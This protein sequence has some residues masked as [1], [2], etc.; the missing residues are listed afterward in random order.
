VHH[1]TTDCRTFQWELNRKIQYGTLQLSEEQQRVHKTPFPNH[2]KDNKAVVHRNASD[3]EVDES[4]VANSSLVP[5]AVRTLQKS[6]KFKSLFNQLRFGSKA[7][8]V[9]T[10]ALITIVAKSGATCFTAEAHASHAF[11]EI[12]NVITFTDEDMKVQ[13]LDHRRPLYLSDVV[14]NIQVRLALIDTIRV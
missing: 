11:L 3:M 2:K 5:T 13:Y 12:T 10:E 7:R 8:S 14:K 1:P 4:V 6:P 9:A